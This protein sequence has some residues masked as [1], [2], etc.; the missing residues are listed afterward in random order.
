MCGHNAI[1]V[2]LWV[3]VFL[4]H[5]VLLKYIFIVGDEAESKEEQT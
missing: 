1:F 2:F 5:F 3:I 4:F